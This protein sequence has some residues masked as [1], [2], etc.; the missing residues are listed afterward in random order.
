MPGHIIVIKM[1]SNP[2]AGVTRRIKW[3]A[4]VVKIQQVEGNQFFRIS[5]VG[6]PTVDH[7]FE[8]GFGWMTI[9]FDMPII[10]AGPL[11]VHHPR[12]P[13]TLARLAL[14]SPVCPNSELGITVPFGYF[15]LSERFP[16]GLK[17]SCSHGLIAGRPHR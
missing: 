3:K 7:F 4:G 8:A 11:P 12:I 14:R 13:V 15:K 16:G 6:F 2:K 17:F 9:V 10:L 1:C 5:L